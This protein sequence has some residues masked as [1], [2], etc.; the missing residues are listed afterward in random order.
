MAE[1][2][3]RAMLYGA[4]LDVIV[5]LRP[6][7]PKYRNWE[8]VELRDEAQVSLY[9]TAGCAHGFQALTDP[10]DVSYR[11]DRPHGPAHD[12]S[13]AFDDPEL[14]SCTAPGFGRDSVSPAC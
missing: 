14:A 5:D 2:K 10:A 8:S 13:I 1:A 3:T 6:A 11:V 4:I 7:S 12:V 9:V